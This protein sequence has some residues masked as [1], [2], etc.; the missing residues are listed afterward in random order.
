MDLSDFNPDAISDILSTLSADDVENLSKI[1][2]QFFSSESNSGSK[3]KEDNRNSSTTGF[4]FDGFDFDADSIMKIM[5][6]FNKLKNQPDDNRIR[7]LYALKPML[8]PKRRHKIDEAVQ[9]L[10]IMTIL[11]L[12]K[13]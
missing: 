5:R 4:G 10:R 3:A 1:A 11:P 9:M 6:L 12:L 7:F 8:T 2:E 13:E